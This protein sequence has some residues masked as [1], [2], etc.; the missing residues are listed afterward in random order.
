MRFRI[1]GPLEV[2]DGEGEAI[3]LRAPKQRTLLAMLLLHA[4]Q[5]VNADR[6][7]AALWPAS[8]PRSATG[9]VRTYVSG[10]RTAVRCGAAGPPWPSTPGSLP[11][12]NAEPGGYRLAVALVIWT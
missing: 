10:L 7:K 4:G 3:P 8:P 12:L 5:P 2:Y 9:I 1:L 11:Q 6:L